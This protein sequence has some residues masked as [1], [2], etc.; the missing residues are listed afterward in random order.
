MKE[1][2]YCLIG[3]D[4]KGYLL[5]KAPRK[6]CIRFFDPFANINNLI[7]DLAK[8]GKLQNLLDELEELDKKFPNTGAVNNAIGAVYFFRG[9][10]EK[11]ID[12]FLKAYKILPTNPKIPYNLGLTYIKLKNFPKAERFLRISLKLDVQREIPKAVF[13]YGYSLY[14]QGKY[15]SAVK[16]FKDY[17]LLKPPET[18]SDPAAYEYLGL[19]YYNL[20][21]LELSKK[22]LK[23]ALFLTTDTEKYAKIACN[24]GNVY[25]RLGNRE[26]AIELYKTSL[27]LDPTL[28]CAKENLKL[29]EGEHECKGRLH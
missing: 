18:E 6:D 2:S 8:K 5:A 29:I 26:R 15:K 11:A 28:E 20:D 1:K 21:K 3:F 19:S 9:E 27:S 24:L 25:L 22:Y 12:Y 10:Y 14:K 4:N 23:R 16:A 13:Y 7:A 17:L